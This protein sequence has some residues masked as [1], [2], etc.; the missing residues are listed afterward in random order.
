[1]A[2]YNVTD[3]DFDEKVIK[4]ATPVLVDFWAPWC[5]PC[6]MA[7]PVLEELSNEYKGK[8]EVVK[9]NVDENHNSSAMY[10]V[11]SIPTTILFKEGKEIG[12]QIGFAGKA[13]YEDLVKKGVI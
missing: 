6:R 10:N 13:A 9:V 1:M 8:V 4:S 11:L 3:S 5:G 7:E 2:T 12:R